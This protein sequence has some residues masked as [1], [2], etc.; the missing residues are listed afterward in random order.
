M[1]ISDFPDFQDYAHWRG[2]NLL[3][4]NTMNLAPGNTYYP[5]L[6]VINWRGLHFHIL[7][8]AGYAQ[9]TVS[10]WQDQAQT[11]NLGGNTWLIPTSIPLTVFIPCRGPY[12][13]LRINNTS[14]VQLTGPVALVGSNQMADRITYPTTSPLLDTGVVAM[15]ASTTDLYP[16]PVIMCG[17]SYISITPSDAAGKVAVTLCQL[18]EAGAISNI[19]ADY[20]TPTAIVREL[21]GLPD[22]PAAVQ[23]INLDNANPHSIAIR[24]LGDIG[25]N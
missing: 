18:T 25:R 23:A 1:S 17:L 12:A 4:F 22:N 8:T 10:W 9:V 5:S 14:A 2:P 6:P 16:L 20:G 15:P 13:Q 21:T 11:I 3:P 19:L 24:L 7:A